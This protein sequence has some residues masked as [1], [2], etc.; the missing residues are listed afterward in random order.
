MHNKYGKYDLV[1]GYLLNK[2]FDYF[3]VGCLEGFSRSIKKTFSMTTLIENE[4]MKEKVG[5]NP[6][7]QISKPLI[8][9]NLI[10]QLE[11]MIVAL[12]KRDLE[13]SKLKETL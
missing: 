10:A 8:N 13:I 11:N 1:Y 12:V 5:E 3:K 6:K 7:W 2:V 4:C 9:K